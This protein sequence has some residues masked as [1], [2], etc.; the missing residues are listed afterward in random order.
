[1]DLEVNKISKGQ[2]DLRGNQIFNRVLAE[3][4]RGVTVLK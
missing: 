2:K 4:S 3:D 1:M